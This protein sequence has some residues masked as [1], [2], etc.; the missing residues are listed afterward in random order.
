MENWEIWLIG[1][2]VGSL[3]FNVMVAAIKLKVKPT[4]IGIAK[5]MFN[6][7]VME[8]ASDYVFFS[9]FFG[10]VLSWVLVVIVGVV[11]FGMMIFKKDDG[12]GGG[13]AI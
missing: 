13:A 2:I 10:F 5:G 9:L 7:A 8:V 4:P 11:L 6:S 1:S 12:A 3:L